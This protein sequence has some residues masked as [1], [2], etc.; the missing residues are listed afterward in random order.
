MFNI[1]NR[2]QKDFEPSLKLFAG[3]GSLVITGIIGFLL[4]AGIAVFILVKGPMIGPEGNV[5][6]AFSFNAAL[7]IFIL[8]I[9]AILPLAKFGNRK[10]KLIRG[11]IVWYAL[12]SYAVETVQNFRG[13][14]P[15]FSQ[16]GTVFDVALGI[17][18]GVVSLVL[19]TLMLFVAIQFFRMKQPYERPMLLM[20]IRYAFLSVMAANLAGIWM[21]VLQDRLIGAAGNIIVLHGMGFH[22]LQTLILT[23]WLLERVQF[24]DRLKK[25]L[26]H[27]GSIAWMLSILL[28][29]LQTILGRSVFELTLLPILSA[30]LLLGWLATAVAAFLILIKQ[31]KVRPQLSKK[32]LSADFGSQ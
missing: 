14:N 1:F 16:A 19:V 6:D 26:I 31:Q 17:S 5:G 4:S 20:G 25:R 30:I 27:S 2:N 32:T 11:Y 22:S 9:A 18:F 7:G 23:A 3:E 24:N 13:F 21:I 29:G 8:S 28:I 12:F 15:R 10:R